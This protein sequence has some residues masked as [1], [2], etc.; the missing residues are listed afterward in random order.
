VFSYLTK[1][2]ISFSFAGIPM[3]G[4][5]D[6]LDAWNGDLRRLA[7]V[8]VLEGCENNE[9]VIDCFNEFTLKINGLKKI[10]SNYES[11]PDSR[12]NTW[13]RDIK[14]LESRVEKGRFGVAAVAYLGVLREFALEDAKAYLFG[15]EYKRLDYPVIKRMIDFF[16]NTDVSTKVDYESIMDCAS[17]IMDYED[18]KDDT[19][20]SLISDCKALEGSAL[21]SMIELIV[22]TAN[23][24]EVMRDVLRDEYD[25]TIV[26][27]K[28]GNSKILR[29]FGKYLREI[30]SVVFDGTARNYLEKE[31]L[32][33]TKKLNKDFIPFLNELIKYH[34]EAV[35]F[36]SEYFEKFLDD[37]SSVDV[38]ERLKAY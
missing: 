23:N 12:Y 11:D 38:K 6:V 37:F 34:K 25:E 27:Y 29:M 18:V 1:S 9:F 5:K 33:R 36:I 16:V 24:F 4:L 22:L 13:M 28:K 26:L 2:F 17:L 30:S 32:S 19:N 15:D 35:V 14:F 21:E 3:N 7:E 10:I 31:L 20:D 8:L